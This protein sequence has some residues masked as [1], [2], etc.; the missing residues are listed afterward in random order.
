M[1]RLLIALALLGLVFPVAAQDEVTEGV[2]DYDYSA[3]VFRLANV[4]RRA[5]GKR[6]FKEDDLLVEYGMVRA[7]E[8]IFS[9]GHFHPNGEYY[10]DQMYREIGRGE[11]KAACGIDYK[12]GWENAA[13]GNF[14][15]PAEVMLG[16]LN[17]RGHCVPL[18]DT[19]LVYLGVG[20][21][22]Q[23]FEYGFKGIMQEFHRYRGKGKAV[24]K[25]GQ[26]DVTVSVSKTK[27]VNSKVLSRKVRKDKLRMYW[28]D[29]VSDEMAGEYDEKLAKDAVD[30]INSTR[31]IN[32]LKPLATDDRLTQLARRRAVE[33]TRLYDYFYRPDGS[34]YLTIADGGKKAADE[35]LLQIIASGCNSAKALSAALTGKHY[36]KLKLLCRDV[37]TIGVACYVCDGREY[38]VI[39]MGGKVG[40]GDMSD[41][42]QTALWELKDESN[43]AVKNSNIGTAAVSA[44][45]KEKQAPTFDVADN[46]TPRVLFRA[47]T[48]YGQEVMFEKKGSKAWVVSAGGCAGELVLPDE[49]EYNGRS[50]P[51]VTIGDSAF[52]GCEGLRSVHIPAGVRRVGKALFAGCT[53]LE[54]ITVAK[55]NEVY[56]SRKGCNAIIKSSNSVLVAGCG[57]TVVPEGVT[58]VMD[59]AFYGTNIAEL[60]LPPTVKRVG[61]GAFAMCGKLAT[62]DLP[63]TVINIGDGA[64]EGCRSLSGMTLPTRLKQVGRRTFMRSGLKSIE[65]PAAIAVVGDSAFAMCTALDTIRVPV[66]VEMIGENAFLGVGFVDYDGRLEDAPWGAREASLGVGIAEATSADTIVVGLFDYDVAVR[67]FDRVNDERAARGLP[68]LKLTRALLE[69]SMIR[70][71][72]QTMRFEARHMRPNGEKCF[73]QCEW[74]KQAGRMRENMHMGPLYDYGVEKMP[75][76]IVDRWMG[77]EGHRN[78]ILAE[79]V[80]YVGVGVFSP[81]YRKNDSKDLDNVY[82][83]Q[84]F[85]EMVMP[86]DA[87]CR[88]SGQEVVAV[89]VARRP[90]YRS[91]VVRRGQGMFDVLNCTVGV[92]QEALRLGRQLIDN[93]AAAGLPPLDMITANL[94]DELHLTEIAMGRVEPRAGEYYLCVDENL[95]KADAVLQRMDGLQQAT[96]DKRISRL[97]L[98]VLRANGKC[99]WLAVLNPK[100]EVYIS[101]SNKP[102]EEA[103]TMFVSKVKGVPSLC[104]ERQKLRL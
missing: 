72:E 13:W 56:D 26:E 66:T 31:K 96:M 82:S 54:E 79:D 8:Q 55:G 85:A 15:S 27:G 93:R 92:S 34:Y 88:P 81:L 10:A 68:P 71:A 41:D 3:E 98:I 76:F 97:E 50:L 43:A 58:A 29:Q 103:C 78:N 23:S 40:S 64:F 51:V 32:R 25:H 17:S 57:A 100:R 69:T 62:V 95:S 35:M 9:G 84:M 104:K 4:E 99:H 39:F 59:S 28:E 101:A 12:T 1:N 37:N 44:D 7:A 22:S 14:G 74:E 36:S 52:V 67:I 49:V 45:V 53:T 61:K 16:W 65:L 86:D 42:E 102:S 30:M 73:T 94:A 24:T 80:E 83:N 75:G 63:Q 11:H 70:A 6:E 48:K 19:A 91:V 90:G 2:F 21:W 47:A 89:R 18:M 60:R 33:L 38:W 20:T 46:P 5:W 77:S 87:E